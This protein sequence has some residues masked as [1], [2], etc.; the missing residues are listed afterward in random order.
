[1]ISLFIDFS[2]VSYIRKAINIWSD[3]QPMAQQLLTIAQKLREE[4]RSPHP[5]QDRIDELLASVYTIDQQLTKL[6]DDFTFTLGKAF[7]LAGKRGAQT[8][9]RHRADC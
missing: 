1:M 7:P 3:A 2:D 9:V 8:V 5:S 4:I 6:E